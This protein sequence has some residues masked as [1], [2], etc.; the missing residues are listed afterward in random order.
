VGWLGNPESI[1]LCFDC[2]WEASYQVQVGGVCLLVIKMCSCNVVQCECGA[3]LAR[4]IGDD[5]LSC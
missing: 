2:D 4:N 3:L 5:L 1:L